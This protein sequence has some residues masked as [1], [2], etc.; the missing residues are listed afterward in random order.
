[1][2]VTCL[3]GHLTKMEVRWENDKEKNGKEGRKKESVEE[4]QE[5]K[6][7][8]RRKRKKQK[9]RRLKNGH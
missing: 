2:S 3:V 1:M 4:E 5:M 7:N 9:K 8:I 6:G